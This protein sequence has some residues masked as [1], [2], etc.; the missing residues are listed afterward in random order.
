MVR[1]S[2][3]NTGVAAKFVNFFWLKMIS[4]RIFESLPFGY[5]QT[6]VTIQL[7]IKCFVHFDEAI[8]KAACML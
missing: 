1:L 5:K 7:K 8:I 3:K 4:D 2:E 6:L